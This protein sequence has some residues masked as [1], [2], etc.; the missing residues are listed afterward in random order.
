MSANVSDGAGDERQAGAAPLVSVGVPV[1]NEERHLAATLDSLLAQDYRNIEVVICDNASTDETPRICAEYAA[2]DARVRYHRNETNIGGINNFNRVFELASGEFFMWAA[3]HDVR[4]PAQIS[5]CMKV[6]SEDNG[7]ILCYSQAVWVNESGEEVEDIHEYLDTRNVFEWKV[8]FNVVLWGLYSGAPV[9]G[10]F[11]SQALRQT[12]L[13]TQVVSPYMSLLIE[14]SVMGRFAYIPEPRFH[15]R[16]L[17][18]HGDW[19][20]FVGKHFK[21]ESSKGSAQSLYWRMMREL[22]RRVARH[23]RTLPGKA[24]GVTFVIA[25]MLIKFRWMLEGLRS[26]KRD[27]PSRL[28]V[29]EFGPHEGR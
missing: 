17:P 9:Y 21:K 8:R 28:P 7:V 24:F 11:R 1:Y 27:D 10:V 12:S 14:L 26:V 2:R 22:S 29:K 15:L 20:A 23:A 13:F 4:H 5:S 16:R 25:A 6:L 19:D 3:G 18:N